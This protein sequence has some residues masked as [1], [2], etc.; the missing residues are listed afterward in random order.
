MSEKKKPKFITIGFSV[1][2]PVEQIEKALEIRQELKNAF[3]DIIK[4]SEYTVSYGGSW[5][6]KEQYHGYPN[7]TCS[8]CD[9]EFQ[10]SEKSNNI[11]DSKTNL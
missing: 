4:P 3:D 8:W 2:Y 1:I 9:R 10:Q 5:E 6:V 7:D 11:N